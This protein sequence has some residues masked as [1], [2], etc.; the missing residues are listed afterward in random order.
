M[1]DLADPK[2]AA[3]DLTLSLT[4]CATVLSAVSVFAVG[5]RLYVRTIV[6]S[7]IGMDDVV[8]TLATVIQAGGSAITIVLGTSPR[9]CLRDIR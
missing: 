3:D 1:D 2:A 8:L 4:I 9:I 6:I 5:L 7:N